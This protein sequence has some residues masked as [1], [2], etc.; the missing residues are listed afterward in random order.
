MY[1]RFAP[2]WRSSRAWWCV[3]RSLRASR[4]NITTI[5]A[6]TVK[7]TT[8]IVRRITTRPDASAGT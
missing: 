6:Y 4:K 1:E 8:I 3:R 7:T 2:L 5:I